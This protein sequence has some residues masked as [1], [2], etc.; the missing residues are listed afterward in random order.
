M[1]LITGETTGAVEFKPEQIWVDEH[2]VEVALQGRKCSVKL[3]QQIHRGD[4]LYKYVA[5][6]EV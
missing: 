6:E 5:A 4:R 2:P 1:V 3:P